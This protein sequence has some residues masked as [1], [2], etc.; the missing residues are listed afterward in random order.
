MRFSF[1]SLLT[2]TAI[3][4]FDL[5]ATAQP[6]LL[7]LA[8][9]AI[10]AAGATP[11]VGVSPSRPAHADSRWDLSARAGSSVFGY[12]VSPG[13]QGRIG[14]QLSGTTLLLDLQ[15]QRG[16]WF[17]R[18]IA[19]E[20]LTT[21]DAQVGARWTLIDRG[22]SALE[23]TSLIGGRRIGGAEPLYAIASGIDVSAVV[24]ARPG[25]RVSA[26]FSNPV[27][28]TSAGELDRVAQ[29]LHAGVE[30]A[31]GRDTWLSAELHGG[32]S[33]G[34]DGDGAKFDT[35]A[36]LGVRFARLDNSVAARPRAQVE[37]AFLAT[38]Y[39]ALGI[40]DHFSNGLG[41]AV[42]ATFFSGHL[43]I[44]LAGFNRPGPIN[45]KTFATTPVDGQTWNGQSQLA[46]RSDGNFVGLHL[47]PVFQL[48]PVRLSVPVTFGQA[49]FG[50]YLH[51]DDRDAVVGERV[52][53]VENRLFDGKDSSFALGAEAG[54]SAAWRVTPW[55]APYASVRYLTTIGYSTLNRDSYGGPSAAFGVEFTP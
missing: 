54:V 46:L 35:G 23:L 16:R 41:F 47:A 42:G 30:V 38:E 6:A 21:V 2:M 19:T 10:A 12:G 52:S 8:D 25:W 40:A 44:G 27:V 53:E 17:P 18:G 20:D 49:A 37:R 5:P 39:R 45:S 9:P 14:Y 43:R 51:G 11:E 22:A 34:Y 50:F 48:G 4:S 32:G 3:V 15:L 13:A 31:V 7:A 33:F 26:G 29:R 36:S 24:R 55:V 1:T 28:I